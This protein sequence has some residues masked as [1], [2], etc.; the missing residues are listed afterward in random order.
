MK[1]KFILLGAVCLATLLPFMTACDPDDDPVLPDT[2]TPVPEPEHP[3]DGADEDGSND[4]NAKITGRNMTVV[5]GNTPFAVTLE[6]NETA[7]AFAALLPM[8]IDMGELNGNE[9]YCYLPQSLTPD[10]YR[11]GTIRA[12]DLMLYGSSC[13]VLFYETFSSGYSYTRIGRIDNPAGLADAVGQGN[14]T[15]AFEISNN[16]NN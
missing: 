7:R 12:G 3:D 15:V 9:K 11:P 6:E 1:R 8:T 10:S 14:I 2:E 4:N 16:I 13:V 5:V